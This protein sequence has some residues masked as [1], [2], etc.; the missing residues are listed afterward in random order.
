MAMI[1]DDET[2]VLIEGLCILKWEW[3]VIVG[4]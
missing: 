4:T 1:S 3:I 2:I